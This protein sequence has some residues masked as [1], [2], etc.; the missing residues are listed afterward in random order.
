MDFFN[1]DMNSLSG[2]SG[3]YPNGNYNA[4]APNDTMGGA[5]M[6]GRTPT[7]YPSFPGMA[8]GMM[9]GDMAQNSMMPPQ[10]GMQMQGNMGADPPA[11]NA[12]S[13][14][15]QQFMEQGYL[16]G[17][18]CFGSDSQR[19]ESQ[20]K[21]YINDEFRDNMYY[22]ILSRRAPTNN[23]RRIF[24]TIAADEMKHARRWAA[25]YFLIT[26]KRYFPTRATVEPVTVPSNYNMALR[27]RYMAESRDAVKY[28][29]FAASTSDRC[30]KRMAT[31]TSDDERQHAQ[32]ILALI[33]NM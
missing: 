17:P 12:M 8:G 18:N 22:M 11:S 26:G 7:L 21:E 25:A 28:R 10:A 14:E 5:D 3:N 27:D 9:A 2:M 4:G 23:A 33:Q 20:L 30:L 31:D 32:D 6:T 29:Q 13:P 1:G 24:R 19:Y 16:M 15:M